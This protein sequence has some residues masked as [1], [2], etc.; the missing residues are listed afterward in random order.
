MCFEYLLFYT[1]FWILVDIFALGNVPFSH[2]FLH[3]VFFMCAVASVELNDE[4]ASQLEGRNWYLV[5]NI[6]YLS[7]CLFVFCILAVASVELNGELVSAPGTASSPHYRS[8]SSRK[9]ELQN[10]TPCPLSFGIIPELQLDD[11]D[12]IPCVIRRHIIIALLLHE[13]WFWNYTEQKLIY[14][15]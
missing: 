12:K 9:P 8:L 5:I 11:L 14:S 10:I 3:F 6:L 2:F 1:M 7:I 15:H 4:L 13:T